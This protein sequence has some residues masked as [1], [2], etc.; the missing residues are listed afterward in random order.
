MRRWE[1][2]E[3][4]TGA[5]SLPHHPR[6]PVS[7]VCDDSPVPLLYPEVPRS[8]VTPE[9]GTGIGGVTHC[10]RFGRDTHSI[11]PAPHICCEGLR[12]DSLRLRV[13]LLT[14]APKESDPWGLVLR[15]RI[16]NDSTLT[17]PPVRER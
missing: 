13:T 17:H 11:P 4:S 9:V 7:P 12:A 8:S 1:S 15:P 3:I 2:P 10:L 5:G 6:D 14:P 16:C